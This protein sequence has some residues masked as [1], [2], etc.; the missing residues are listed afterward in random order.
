MVQRCPC[1]FWISSENFTSIAVSKVKYGNLKWTRERMQSPT[2]QAISVRGIPSSTIRLNF[3]CLSLWS[4][5][6][7][8]KPCVA[9]DLLWLLYSY[10]A[11][12]PRSSFIWL[13]KYIS[14]FSSCRRKTYYLDT[15]DKLSGIWNICRPVCTLLFFTC[16]FDFGEIESPSKSVISL[17]L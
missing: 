15:Q 6:Q 3:P 11:Q 17:K 9:R 5:D 12:M 8:C 14:L 2:L 16:L 13:L 10:K 7:K 1:K 4:N